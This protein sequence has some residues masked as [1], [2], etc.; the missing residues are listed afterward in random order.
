MTKVDIVVS[1]AKDGFYSVYVNDYPALF[2]G[3][4]T[5]ENAVAELRETLRITKEEVGKDSALSYPEWLDGDYQFVM[6]W[7]VQDLLEYY[8]GIINPA[9][10]GRITGIH[11]KQLWAYRSGLS[12]PR[13]KQVD[14]IEAALHKLGRELTQVSFR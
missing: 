14:K 3:G 13:K 4:D 9:A 7:N 12:K 8:S 6:H 1:V 10:L 2:G 11:P 5:V